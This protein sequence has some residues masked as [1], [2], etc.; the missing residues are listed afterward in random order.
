[1]I[2]VPV[3]CAAG[4]WTWGSSEAKP[5]LYLLSYILIPYSVLFKREQTSALETQLAKGYI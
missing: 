5:A 4:D 1:M 2:S 3:L